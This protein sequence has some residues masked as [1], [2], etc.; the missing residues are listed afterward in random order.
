MKKQY[1]FFA[2]WREQ[3]LKFLNSLGLNKEIEPGVDIFYVEESE[4]YDRVVEHYSRKGQLFKR[5]RPKGFDCELLGVIFS[6][7]ELDF[8]KGFSLSL[9]AG[10][11]EDLWADHGTWKTELYDEVCPNCGRPI[12][13]QKRPWVL[14]K[15]FKQ[16]VKHPF[17]GFE[18]MGGF[19]FCDKTVADLIQKEFGIRQMEVLIGQNEKVSENLV[20][21]TIPLSP[22]N[23]NVEG[24][25]FGIPYEGNN[26]VLCAICNQRTFTNQILDFFPPFEKE[27]EYDIVLTREWF[28]WYRRFVLSKRFLDFCFENKLTK[29]R[30]GPGFV[31][32]QSTVKQT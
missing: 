18:G 31:V 22:Y 20:Q 28:G 26:E 13:E 12:G 19:V 7:K 4:I 29:K 32:P 1:S 9:G 3:D 16:L 2:E 27:F 21:L 8:A 17:V 24:N 14:K 25:D 30:F 6:E 5:I 11:L 15:D 23:L 10:K